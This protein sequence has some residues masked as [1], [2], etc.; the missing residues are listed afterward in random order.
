MVFAH[1]PSVF[2]LVS[3]L[4]MLLGALPARFL[5]YDYFK[6][7]HFLI[8]SSREHDYGDPFYIW[9]SPF[10]AHQ[11]LVIFQG[12]GTTPFWEINRFEAFLGWL[13]FS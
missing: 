7:L 11:L 10:W 1:V 4:L 9:S 13:F 5:I 2:G 12:S 8:L 6:L 3:L